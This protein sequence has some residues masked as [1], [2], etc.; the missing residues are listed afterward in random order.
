MKRKLE[1]PRRGRQNRTDSSTVPEQEPKVE[2]PARGADGHRNHDGLNLLHERRVGYQAL[3]VGEAHQPGPPDW[4]GFANS[5]DACSGQG[6]HIVVFQP[7]KRRD[8]L[9][10]VNLHMTEK[11]VEKINKHLIR[12][13]ETTAPKTQKT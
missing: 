8:Q 6:N 10:L 12:F 4:T 1:E 13:F 9:Q 5:S 3:R 11:T 7:C 2:R